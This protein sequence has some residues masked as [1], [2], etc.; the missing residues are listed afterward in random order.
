M[1]D[2]LTHVVV[3]ELIGKSVCVLSLDIV[4]KSLLAAGPGFFV[5]RHAE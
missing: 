3:G 4:T 5:A 2:E 1:S